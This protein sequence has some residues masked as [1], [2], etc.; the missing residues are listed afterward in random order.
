MRCLVL[1]GI[2]C[3]ADALKVQNIAPDM[4]PALNCLRRST[5]SL[6]LKYPEDA[7]EHFKEIHQ[8]LK[9]HMHLEQGMSC[10]VGYCGP[11]IENAWMEHFNSTWNAQRKDA[12]LSSAFG[13]YIPIFFPWVDR[14]VKQGGNNAQGLFAK[15]EKVLR[16]DVAYITVSQNDEGVM[17]REGNNNLARFPNLLVLSGGGYGH[18]P[19]PLLIKERTEEEVPLSQRDHFISFMGTLKTAPNGLRRKM[20]GTVMANKD[21][22]H[23]MTVGKS[24]D[25][26]SVMAHSRFIMCPRGF[27]RTSFRLGESV[28]MGRIPVYVYSDVAWVPYADMFESFGYVAKI[29]KL[30][31]LVKRLKTVGDDEVMAKENKLRQITKSHF[32]LNGMMEQISGFMT[33]KTPT[34]LRCQAVPPTVRDTR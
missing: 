23:K 6:E 21:D 5:P 11:W 10:Y 27:G 14:W 8:V 33:S 28:Q 4:S 19:V 29:D 13:P 16:K 17:A 7:E 26:A 25:W 15:L 34:D 9:P 30:D 22:T 31:G 20:S 24:A 32:T 2:F 3:V 1:I 12:R 18:V